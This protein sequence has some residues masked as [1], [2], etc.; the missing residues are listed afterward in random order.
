M[1]FE[2]AVQF[3]PYLRE[4]QRTEKKKLPSCWANG[5]SAGEK[6]GRGKAAHAPR[7][8]LQ[9]VLRS[10]L[11]ACSLL[12]ANQG[13]CSSSPA[14]AQG[15]ACPRTR[16]QAGHYREGAEGGLRG[17]T[18]LEVSVRKFKERGEEQQDCVGG[19]WNREALWI[20]WGRITKKGSERAVV[21]R[22]GH[23]RDTEDLAL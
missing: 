7:E 2:L 17:N 5:K 3:Q 12:L 11:P 20:L 21:G 16:E 23:C 1:T 13:R 10:S 22:R 6:K 19:W 8:K 9:Y 15:A 4:G 14:P 18:K